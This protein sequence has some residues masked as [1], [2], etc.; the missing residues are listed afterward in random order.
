MDPAATFG[1]V[2]RAEIP[3]GNIAPKSTM[4]VIR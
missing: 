4:E 3:R 2:I 1:K